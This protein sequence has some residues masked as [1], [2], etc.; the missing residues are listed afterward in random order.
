[1]I[2]VILTK[3]TIITKIIDKTESGKK[4]LRVL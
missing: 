1:M 3:K 4:D 2:S